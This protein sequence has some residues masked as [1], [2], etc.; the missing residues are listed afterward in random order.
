M[1]LNS[2]SPYL[3]RRWCRLIGLMLLLLSF[4]T[5]VFAVAGGAGGGGGGGGGD[6]GDLFGA[7]LEIIFWAILSLPFPFNVIVIGIIVVV[8]F[9]A[10]SQ[11]RGISQLNSIPAS[12][13]LP[14]VASGNPIA[15][16]ESLMKRN[17]DFIPDSLLAKVR[18]AFP[19]IQKAWSAQNLSSVRRWISDGVW[20]RFNTQFAMMQLLGQRN[21]VSNVCVLRTWIDAVEEDGD[22]DIVHVGIHFVAQD[23]FVSDKLPELNQCGQITLIEFWT[24]MRKAGVASKDLYHSNACPS[25]GAELPSDMGEV[26]QCPSCK[27]VSTLGDYDWVLCEI[28]QADD[29]RNQN[30]K[31]GKSGKLTLKLRDA[32]RVG[33]DFAVQAI[34]DKASNAYLQILAAQVLQK[35]EMMRRFVSD[36]VFESAQRPASEMH[37]I[38]NRLYLNNVTAID[39][40]RAEGKNHVVVAIKRTAQRVM[41][42]GEKLRVLDRGLYASDQILVLARDEEGTG[43]AKASL[44]A[45]ACPACGAPVVDTLDVKCAYC[46]EVLNS[47]S[48][49]WIVTQLLS[50]A[51]YRQLIVNQKPQMATKVSGDDLDPLY[52]VRD[53]V[54]NN[55]LMMIGIDGELSDEEMAFARE[56]ARKFG[57][58]EDKL[59]GIFELAKGRKLVLRLPSTRKA[60]QKV[61]AQMEK[62]ANADNRITAEEKALLDDVRIRVEAIWAE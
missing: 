52:A 13:Q 28:T 30:A 62:A 53:Y 39:A 51:E 35:P 22:Y 46:G 36:A 27:T 31:L 60:A 16:P 14:E 41:V 43:S 20:Q 12:Q 56:L 17:P 42:E 25:C 59:A 18:T 54:F 47:T 49:E 55:V 44:Y 23:D 58:K 61:L 4:S 2:T 1:L 7:L 37:C 11:F 26:A 48:R 45:H 24:F 3:G 21:V 19:A 6:G 9:Y 57:Y 29:Y 34:E 15:M 10:R 33:K 8:V 50:P 32:L 5:L 38:F 40:Y